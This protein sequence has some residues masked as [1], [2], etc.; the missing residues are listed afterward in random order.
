MHKTIGLPNSFK[1]FVVCIKCSSIYEYNHFI[2]RA[3]PIPASK[4]CTYIAYPNHT[5]STRRQPCNAILLKP[6]EFTSGHTILYPRSVYCYRSLKDGLQDLLLN[7]EF[8]CNSQLWRKQVQIDN[9]NLHSIYNGNV[10][11][12]FFNVTESPLIKYSF[13][14]NKYSFGLSLNIDWFQP[15][16]HTTS[17]VGV[18]YATVLNLPRY[19]RYKRQNV[20]LL[21]IIPGPQEPKKN[22]N[23][24]LQPLVDELQ[25]FWAGINLTICTE[26]G[27]IVKL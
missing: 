6:V 18:I 12:E 20:I 11:K 4:C 25:Q 27:K 15:Y 1:K 17:S 13:S 7:P 3:S 14:V 22:I 10:W 26:S 23:T 2:N 5:Q 16:I 24:F 21:G 9:N 8:V 19:L